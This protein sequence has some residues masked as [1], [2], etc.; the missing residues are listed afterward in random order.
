MIEMDRVQGVIFDLDGTLL[1]SMG[2]WQQVDREYLE[3]FGL[4][5]PPDLQRSIAGLSVT[6][7][8]RYFKQRFRLP[9]SI[10]QIIADWNAMAREEYLSRLPLKP[11]AAELVRHLA[12]A[13][14]KLGIATTSYRDLTEGCLAR[15]GILPFFSSIVTSADIQKGKPD[16]EIFLKAADLMGVA[17]EAC[18]VFEDMPEGLLAGKRAGMQTVA[19]RDTASH[20]ADEEKRMLADDC[21]ASPE[22]WLKRGHV[23][24]VRKA[25]EENVSI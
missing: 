12:G 1:D 20:E 7:T 17:A 4:E 22:E 13:G 9:D 25:E 11:G 16:P 2:M 10:E 5:A 8:A 23:R 18:L 24:T 21:T 6:D 3:R 15:H 19:V 14:L